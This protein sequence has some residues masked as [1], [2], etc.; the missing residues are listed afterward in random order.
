MQKSHLKIDS[1]DSSW[2]SRTGSY[3]TKTQLIGLRVWAHFSTTVNTVYMCNYAQTY[4]YAFD[5]STRCFKTLD[6]MT[7]V[8]NL[9]YASE[10]TFHHIKKFTHNFLHWNERSFVTSFVHSSVN[11]NLNRI[12][13]SL[14]PFLN[15]LEMFRSYFNFR[16]QFHNHSYTYLMTSCNITAKSLWLLAYRIHKLKWPEAFK[17][18]THNSRNIMIIVKLKPNYLCRICHN[19][20]NCVVSSLKKFKWLEE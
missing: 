1:F 18:K 6:I 5:C 2:E 4:E 14:K 11:V 12:Q 3:N 10:E 19:T 13:N 20:N 15:Q 8:F 7:Q 16:L 9:F 17:Y